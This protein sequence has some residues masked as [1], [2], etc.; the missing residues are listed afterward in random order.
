MMSKKTT[1]SSFFI[2]FLFAVNINAQTSTN[3]QTNYVESA[4]P[5]LT[6]APDSRAGAMGDAGVATSPDINSMHWNPAKYAFIETSSGISV[7]YSPWLRNLIGDINLAY[8]T[9]YYRLN[10]QQ[11]VATS[12]RYF[13]LGEIPFTNSN[14]ELERTVKPNE[15]AFDVAYSRLF[16]EKISGAIAFR[17]IRSDLS[18]GQ[19]VQNIETK[20]GQAFAAD[21]AVY[22]NT[23]L[24]I[25]E[26]NSKLALGLDISNIGTKIT[27]TDENQKDFLP[28][29]LR[30]GGALTV[31]LD[32]YNT[33]TFT[34]D[35]NKLL[36]PTGR[37][38]IDNNNVITRNTSNISVV[39]GIF[40]SFSDAPGGLKE[41]LQ[42]I[43]YSIGGE[44]WYRKQ[45]A[46]RGGYFHESP[47]KGNRKFF[48]MGV[49]L[50]LNV[51]GLDFSYL[52]SNNN[53][54]LARTLRFSISLDF[55]GL[56]KT[57]SIK[58]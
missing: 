21:L 49:G 10:Q 50:K 5:F 25:S 34:T 7:S 33:V 56:K 55:D 8:L 53:N 9:G 22:Y 14:S 41:E 54:P 24:T 26:K 57:K 52:V 43:T 30:L 16:S 18:Q 47:N 17:Y 11:V 29:N 48:T 36:I 6:I 23:P 13:S 51:I 42:E 45:L 4:V 35:F 20:A 32:Q 39:S 15:L 58:S 40:Q 31:D 27:Y 3:G 28:T 37:Y 12:L 19:I 1:I 38:S 46:I 44:Y 2:I